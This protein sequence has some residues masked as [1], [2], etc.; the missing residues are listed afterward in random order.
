MNAPK[1]VGINS[2]DIL[3]YFSKPTLYKDWLEKLDRPLTKT[4][5]NIPARA[6]SKRLEHKNIKKLNGIPLLAYSIIIAK[7]IPAV[8]RVFINT[9]SPEY[10]DIAREFGA[11]VPFIRPKEFAED[12]SSMEKANYFLIRHLMEENY[13]AGAMVTLYPT[14]PFRNI[15]VM[16]QLTGCLSSHNT[17]TTCVEVDLDKNNIC[18][19]DGAHIVNNTASQGLIAG[20][21]LIKS[22]GSFLGTSIGAGPADS[23]KLYFHNN[24]IETIDIDTMDD[25]KL[26]EEIVNSNL[27]D[28]GTSI[29]G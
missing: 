2:P 18:M 15:S 23:V 10:A 25:F 6:S 13:P 3:K 21:T 1:G 12:S 29:C 28:F 16:N 5:I 19:D 9:D 20:K 4:I 22:T 11:E 17:V 24:P 14:S 7:S 26:A 27:Y 8:D